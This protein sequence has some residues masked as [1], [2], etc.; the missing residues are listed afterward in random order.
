MSLGSGSRRSGALLVEVCARGALDPVVWIG[1]GLLTAA[2]EGVR[3]SGCLADFVKGRRPA[4]LSHLLVRASGRKIPR[5]KSMYELR[6]VLQGPLSLCQPDRVEVVLSGSV[7]EP[8]V[9]L[10]GL[11]KEGMLSSEEELR[12]AVRVRASP[13]G[14]I[15]AMAAP[16]RAGMSFCIST[17]QSALARILWDLDGDCSA[18]G[19]VVASLAGLLRMAARPIPSA[20]VGE[21]TSCLLYTS[22]SPRDRG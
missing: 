8:G 11:M 20:A 13:A 19:D 9:N 21:F 22:P 10:H 7:G 5:L 15:S 4:V 6:R 14:C 18:W 1:S 17:F 16:V 12:G 2:V 3:C